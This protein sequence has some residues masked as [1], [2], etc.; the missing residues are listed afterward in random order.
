[1]RSSVHVPCKLMRA[2][3]LSVC[4]WGVASSVAQAQQPPPPAFLAVV[5]GN[6]TL[7]R[8]GETIPAE[9][10]MPFVQGDRLRTADG[11]V[12]IVFQDGTAIEVAEYSE[13]E[14]MSPTR[15]RLLAGTM[16]HVQ[17]A[18]TA[19]QS[20]TYLP[21]ELDVY[22]PTLD[23]NGAW[24][25]DAP[26]GYVWYPTVAADWRPYYNG[27]WSAVPTYG[28]TWI[29]ADR[30][31]WPTHHYG[32]WGF[33]RNRWFWIPG[34]T[35][36]PAWVSWASSP[37]YVGWCPLGFDSR[38]VFAF[39]TGYGIP[40]SGWTVLSRGNFGAHRYYANRFSVDPRRL[41]SN[42]SF[43][44]RTAPPAPPTR[45]GRLNVNSAPSVGVGVPR[46][47]PVTSRQSPVALPHAQGDPEQSRRVG[48]PRS[49]SAPG[50]QAPAS[51]PTVRPGPADA[52][53]PTIGER[54]VTPAATG[55]VPVHY[56]MAVPRA[57][58]A[59]P[60]T[61]RPPQNPEVQAAP[62]SRPPTPA[63]RSPNDH[64]IQ[65]MEPRAAPVAP[66]AP[67]TSTPS[68]APQSAPAQPPQTPPA[69]APHARPAPPNAAPQGEGRARG[70]GRGRGRQ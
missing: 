32:R 46:Q 16:D 12:Q 4:V 57:T 45:A 49:P 26:Y 31:A 48:S 33:A 66:A 34:R 5:E 58:T 64:R 1:M 3:F 43:V 25:Y 62:E 23:Q 29:G 9:Q 54:R 6:A 40:W 69:S 21:Q 39:N 59:T 7:E 56:G 36:G 44:P 20:A 10:N 42:V 22:G 15:V 60:A 27:Y 18:V 55:Q 53:Q 50:R 11:R 67:S 17:R 2:L 61:G 35:W 68:A 19:S 51:T 13:V 24:Q 14:C 8:D 52:G 63:Y 37:A 28:Y 38:P 65:R 41:P 30:W 70:E 47:S